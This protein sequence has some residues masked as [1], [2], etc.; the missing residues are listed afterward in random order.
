M[1]QENILGKEKIGKLILKFSIPCIVSML[2]NSLYNIVD[3][4]FIGQG[5]GTLG[6]GAT[7][8]VFPLVMIGLAFSLMFGD[9]AS[10][11]LSLKLGEK[12]KKEAEKGIGNGI[13][14]SA[15]VS[16]IFCVITL[17]FLPQLLTL[18]GCTDKLRDLAMTYGRIIA[19]GF[20]FSMI[21]TTLN[22][23]IRADG[24]PKFAMTSMVTGAILHTIL[25]PIF[26]FVFHKGVAGAAIATVFSQAVSMIT[27]IVVMIRNDF[28]FDF[29]PSSFIIKKEK[30]IKILKLGTPTAI[31]N[32]VTSISFMIITTLVNIIGGVNASAAVGVVA[33]FNS[34]AVLPAV[35]MGASIS[36]MCAQNIGAGKWDR[37]V[38]TCKIGTVIAFCISGCIFIVAQTSFEHI[39]RLFNDEPEM[40][41]YGVQYIRTFSFDYLLMPFVFCINGLFTG[42]GHTAFS[43][44]NNMLSAIVLRV[45]VAVAFGLV[46]NLGLTGV[47]LGGPM[48]SVGAIILIVVFLISG[49]WKENKAL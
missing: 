15:I 46:L 41:K 35:A 49:R 24:N 44:V 47:G 37:A 16:I 32:G 5:V 30:A 14:L 34:F 6:N 12:K 42:A 22:S 19:I 33:K 10:A 13:L 8:V 2:V 40:I 43:M 20:P 11:Y 18:F 29:K 3:Q 31:Q 39:L 4:I 21:G 27:C 17:I 25:D 28:V 7:N 45:P 38:K 36:T 23:I 9:G 26:I 1:E 48:A